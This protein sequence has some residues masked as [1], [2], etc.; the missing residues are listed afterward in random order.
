MM[1]KDVIEKI[2]AAFVFLLLVYSGFE[3]ESALCHVAAVY[4]FFTHLFD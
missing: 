4:V 3:Y 1:K 2:I